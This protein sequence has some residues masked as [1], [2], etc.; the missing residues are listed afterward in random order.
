MNATTTS[1]N[2]NITYDGS[3]AE[4]EQTC[5]LCGGS[6]ATLFFKKVLGKYDIAYL[7]CAQCFSL[8]TERPYWLEEAYQK[9]NLSN[10]DTGA[11]QRNITNLAATYAISKL[12]KAKNVIDIG[13]GDGLLCRLLRDYQINCYLQDKYATPTY[14]QGF[15]ERD[16]VSPDLV[17]GFEVL[18]HYPNPLSDLEDL[19]LITPLRF[20]CLPQS[21]TIKTKTGGT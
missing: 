15:T 14:G 8:L 12:L 4:S 2:D 11:A 10:A 19:F 1:Y 16:F 17:V 18:E 6:L 5:R 20:Y 3:Q 7:K 21:I 13:G 9:S